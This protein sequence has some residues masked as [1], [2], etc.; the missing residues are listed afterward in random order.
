MTITASFT[1]PLTF[2][3]KAYYSPTKSYI[4]D[5]NPKKHKV[6]S[7]HKA[8]LLFYDFYMN[9]KNTLPPKSTVLKYR[10][11]IEMLIVRGCLPEDAFKKMLPKLM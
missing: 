11:A 10:V 1:G 6:D 8:A 3:R 9:N 2:D 5:K 4:N 7:K